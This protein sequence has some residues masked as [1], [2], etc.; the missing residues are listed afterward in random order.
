MAR[1]VADENDLT[2]ILIFEDIGDVPHMDFEPDIPARQMCALAESGE[3]WL[4]TSWPRA[5]KTGETF[6]QHQPP[7]HAG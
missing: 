4:N 6:L 2:K 7:N 5:R 1:A 3:S